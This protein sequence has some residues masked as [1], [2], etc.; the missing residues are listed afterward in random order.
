[1]KLAG[2]FENNKFKL[3][4]TFI[5][6]VF[7]LNLIIDLWVLGGIDFVYSLNTTLAP[8]A[9]LTATIVFLTA[10]L[11]LRETAILGKVLGLLSLG[12][13]GWAVAEVIWFVAVEIQG[14]EL[15]YPSFSDAIWLVGYLPLYAALS[16]QYKTVQS[17]I[18]Q[19]QRNLTIVF[20][21]L[22]IAI[23]GYFV[24]WPNIAYFDPEAIIVGVLNVLYPLMDVV[25]FV[26]AILITFSLVEG[27]FATFWRIISAGFILM[28]FGDLLFSYA[29]WN[30]I[31]W[32]EGQ[33]NAITIISDT[34]YIISYF[35]LALGAFAYILIK[36]MGQEISLNSDTKALLRTSILLI[37]NADRSVSTFS[38][39]FLQLVK[40]ED[41]TKYQNSSLADV[42]RITPAQAEELTNRIG[43]ETAITNYPLTIVDSEGQH[44]ETWI[45]ALSHNSSLQTFNGANI[46]LQANI[47]DFEL[48]EE[49]PSMNDELEAMLKFV[50]E[51]TGVQIQQEMQIMKSYFLEII[52]LLYALV[53]QYSGEKVANNLLL[54]LDK[55]AQQNSWDIRFSESEIYLTVDF[56]G[57]ALA[58]CLSKLLVE[59]KQYASNMTS[60]QILANEIEV[61]DKSLSTDALNVITRHQ[62]RSQ[63]QI[64]F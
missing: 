30:E 27:R 64:V 63:R 33:I 50:L 12:L 11:K 4:I 19:K 23:S 60:E 59:A 7:V 6:F 15:P 16:I 37:I 53:K 48:G 24:L 39:N 58:D 35:V 38:N 17:K 31:Y 2:I 34:S 44:L 36:E 52:K 18:S 22:F 5:A 1:M 56:T 14:I 41:K 42:L 49:F 9:A 29:V 8:I 55:L 13:S 62:L 57:Q 25:L 10:W 28:T 26:L 43:A 3:A 51:K 61:L 21:L 45:T 46:V 20:T 47:V 32:P 40:S 54:H